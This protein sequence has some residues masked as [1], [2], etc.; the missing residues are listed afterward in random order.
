MFNASVH[1]GFSGYAYAADEKED[2]VKIGTDDYGRAIVRESAIKAYTLNVGGRFGVQVAPA[3][4]F[5]VGAE[6]GATFGEEA[7]L[8]TEQW[9]V[10]PISASFGARISF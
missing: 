5:F 7:A 3:L 9:G 2:P 10:S 1:V 8:I 4:G 6:Y